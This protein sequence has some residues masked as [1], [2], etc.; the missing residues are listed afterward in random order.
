MGAPFR[1]ARPQG[2][3]RLGAVERLDLRLLVD[4]QNH[5]A[6]RRMEIE[7]YD[8]AHLLDEQ[9][10]AGQLEG[11]DTVRLEGEGL[12]D[13]TD[14][15]R[16]EP[17]R[18]GHRARAPMLASWGIDSSV[19]VTTRSTSA[20]LILRGAP[21]L[22]SS[23]RPSQRAATNRAATCRPCPA[24]CPSARRPQ[25]R[26]PRPRWPA[27]SARAAP[28]PAMSSDAAPSAPAPRARPPKAAA[29]PGYDG[30]PSSVPRKTKR[31]D[32]STSPSYDKELMRQDTSQ[33]HR[34]RIAGPAGKHA[35]FDGCR[36]QIGFLRIPWTSVYRNE[37]R[38][39]AVLRGRR[40]HP[41][42]RHSIVDSRERLGK[43]AD[44][45]QG[46]PAGRQGQN[47]CLAKRWRQDRQP[48]KR[49]D[50]GRGN[51]VRQ[52][53]WRRFGARHRGGRSQTARR[54]KRGAAAAL[55][56]PRGAFQASVSRLRRTAT[57]DARY[58]PRSARTAIKGSSFSGQAGRVVDVT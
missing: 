6:L 58:S 57:P 15:C 16:A 29:P 1:Q 4:A 33:H 7:A 48:R 26:F 20:S 39:T 27:R 49:P 13:A 45:I 5:R 11:L 46:K 37:P 53:L 44:R 25:R 12:P 54:C 51:G 24:W 36:F 23:S 28:A 35:P 32:G 52:C 38:M 42:G 2:Q 30:S 41:S 50:F 34:H 31:T 18:P 19:I 10:I 8:I 3:Q 21:G 14:R 55:H 47:R 43:R 56:R 22:V 17:A 40:P 9:G